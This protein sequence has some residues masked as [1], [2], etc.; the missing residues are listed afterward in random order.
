[1][2]AHENIVLLHARHVHGAT[3]VDIAVIQPNTRRPHLRQRRTGLRRNVHCEP[4]TR[5]VCSGAG[6]SAS[7]ARG[8]ASGHR[9]FVFNTIPVAN[10]S[11]PIA[12]AAGISQTRTQQRRTRTQLHAMLKPPAP[13][14]TGA[15]CCNNC[16]ARTAFLDST[17]RDERRGVARN[18]FP[19]A[20]SRLKGA[21]DTL[22]PGTSIHRNTRQRG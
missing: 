9:L 17:R 5:R 3:I 1:M 20:S 14:R 15:R 18:V 16:T 6:P 10:T 21:L 2:H 11:V 13:R 12:A 19:C 8:Q 4:G 22:K 7:R